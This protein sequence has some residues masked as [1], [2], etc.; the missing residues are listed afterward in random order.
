MNDREKQVWHAAFAVAAT[1]FGHDANPGAIAVRCV[2]WADN[3][4]LALRAALALDPYA[5]SRVVS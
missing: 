2:A 5:G 3:A 1:K 4:V